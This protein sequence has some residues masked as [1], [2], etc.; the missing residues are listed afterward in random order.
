M[1]PLATIVLAWSLAHCCPLVSSYRAQGYSDAQI[2]A[3][4]REASVPKWVIAWAR[5]NCKW[6]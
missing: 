6:A 4:A 1:M 3:V 2:E 5:R